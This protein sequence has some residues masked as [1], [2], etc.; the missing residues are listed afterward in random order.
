[1]PLL[2]LMPFA[3]FSCEEDEPIRLVANAGEDFSGTV[4]TTITLD[5]SA[6]TGP[7]NFQYEWTYQ[8]GSVQITDVSQLQMSDNFS[9]NPTF[10]PP[11]N[12]EYNFTLRIEHNGSFSEDQIKVTISGVLSLPAV[13]SSNTVLSDIETD[14]TKP[15]YE[16]SGIV[17]IQSGGALSAH[18]SAQSIVLNFAENAG[19]I[20]EGGGANL[21][22]I[23]LTSTNGWKGIL[24]SGGSLT[25]EAYTQIVKGGKSAFNGQSETAALTMTGGSLTLY[26]TQFL[27]TQG[28]YDL[29]VTGGSINENFAGNVFSSLKPIKA[30]IKYVTRFYGNTYPTNYDYLYLT[31]SGAGTVA[32]AIGNSGFQFYAYKYFIDGDFTAGSDVLINQSAKIFMKPGAGF[33]QSF[34]NISSNGCLTCSPSTGPVIDGLNGEPWKGIAIGFNTTVNL[35]NIEIKNAG[36]AVFNTGSFNSAVKASIYFASNTN[37]TLTSSMITNSGGYGVYLDSQPSFMRVSSTIFTGTTQAAMGVMATHVQ[38]AI[39]QS[40][41]TFTMPDGVPAVEV[42]STNP[43]VNQVFGEWRALSND[44]YYLITGSL[45]QGNNTWTLSPGAK[46]RFKA[47]KS[48]MIQGG[49]FNAIGTAELPIILDSEAGTPGTWPGI[50]L[51]STYKIEHCQIKNGGEALLFRGG[52]SP[53][54]SLANVVFNYGGTSN[55]NTFKNNTISGGAGYGVL[56]EA[57]K[58]N[59][60]VLNVANANTFT[61][62][63]N[64]DVIVK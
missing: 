42:R 21:G 41:N 6:S 20:I 51:E 48:I 27:E 25:T 55:A 32:T 5:G 47:G 49:L 24:L 3:F 1:M 13:I 38:N 19:L 16:I 23:S 7:Q 35:A 30:D 43:S 58:Q 15:D 28:S 12:G 52:V 14:P 64:G 29:L 61:N 18:A 10:I 31:T 45:V 40:P 39:G 4:A 17:T 56:V 53:A 63:V 22:K 37:C 50:I 59:P 57:T 11:K 26:G 2:L 8:G 46:L 62:N 9:A 60:D 44:H 54:T 34:G 36:S 33:Y